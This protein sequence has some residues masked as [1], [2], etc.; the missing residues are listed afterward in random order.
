MKVWAF[1]TLDIS[2]LQW[3]ESKVGGYLSIQ[4]VELQGFTKPDTIPK[5]YSEL[6]K[7][8]ESKLY[9]EKYY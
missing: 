1:V 9:L 5:I 2:M 6:L 7:L 3:L 4:I 8:G